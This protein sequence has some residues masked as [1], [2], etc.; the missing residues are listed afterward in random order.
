MGQRRSPHTPERPSAVGRS[1]VRRAVEAAARA[2][3]QAQHAHRQA[4]AFSLR[5]AVAH[6]HA[7]LMAHESG[8]A[9]QAS[10]HT[11]LADRARDAARVQQALDA[12]G[13]RP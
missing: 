6:E 5:A 3:A 10:L 11:D 2:E 9:N 13:R 1:E 4:M 7:A 8:M 12:P